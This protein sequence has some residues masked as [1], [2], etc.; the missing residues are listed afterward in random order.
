MSDTDLLVARGNGVATLTINRPAEGNRITPAA[1][2]RLAA[3][4]GEFARDDT[5]QAVIITGS[6][7]DHFS[8][9]ILNPT[10]R[11]QLGKGEI[12][13]LVQLAIA[14]YEAVEALPQIVIAALNGVTRAGAAELAL[15]CDIRL[16]ADHVRLAF[17]EAQWGGF[18]GAGGP[19]RL[20]ALIG[21]ARA[22]ELICTGREI[23]A[24]EMARIGLV[25]AT[26][27]AA[28]LMTAA[29]AMAERIAANGPLATRGAKRI[30][31]IRA[32]A[33][34]AAARHAASELRRALEWSRDVD[35]AI[36]AQR[37]GRTPRFTGQ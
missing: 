36:A 13:D 26:H 28:T 22:L 30:D 8:T 11:A 27:S 37:E 3:C 18:P 4:C 9:G 31:R 21:R 6:G 24:E 34:E 7:N 5:I 32:A 29:R 20:P 12:L 2:H 16:A 14:T 10:I 35:E 33:G 15:A 17:P 19:V 25:V 1:L 23:D